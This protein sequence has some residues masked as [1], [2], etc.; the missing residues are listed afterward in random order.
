MLYIFKIVS[1]LTFLK[2]VL[3]IVLIKCKK[4][5]NL[6]LHHWKTGTT[7]KH[8]VFGQPAVYRHVGQ[9]SACTGHRLWVQPVQ[10]RSVVQAALFAEA[11]LLISTE[12][13]YSHGENSDRGEILPIGRT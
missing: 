10:I 9:I 2:I 6:L 7:V 8:K 12:I 3:L 13:L 4:I 1:L 11:V 5:V